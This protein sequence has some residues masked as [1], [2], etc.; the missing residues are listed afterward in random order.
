MS[1]QLTCICCNKVY[2]NNNFNFHDLCH[3]CFN[4]Y[5]NQKMNG[6]FSIFSSTPL[7][8][9]ESSKQFVES[10]LCTHDNKL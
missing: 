8:Y 7:V 2:T 4:H 5:D 3:L 10:G 9:I 1:D 6:R